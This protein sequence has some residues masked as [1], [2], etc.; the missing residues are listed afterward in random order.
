MRLI[1]N[2]GKEDTL[3]YTVHKYARHVQRFGANTARLVLIKI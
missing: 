3:I 1:F 2:T